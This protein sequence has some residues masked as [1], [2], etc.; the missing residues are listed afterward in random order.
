MPKTTIA[1]NSRGDLW[2]IFSVSIIFVETNNKSFQVTFSPVYDF[3]TKQVCAFENWSAN[4]GAF[5][6]FCFI[7]WKA[8]I[9]RAFEERYWIVQNYL[10]LDS[11]ETEFPN[12]LEGTFWKNFPKKFLKDFIYFGNRKILIDW[13]V[14]GNI[15]ILS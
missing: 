9:W 7:K 5:K 8:A 4:F 11:T 6:N 15:K 2:S 1:T 10:E 3:V 13:M 12:N 14:K